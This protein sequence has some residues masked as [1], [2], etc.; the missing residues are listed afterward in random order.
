MFTFKT[1]V[2][3]AGKAEAPK[4]ATEIANGIKRKMWLPDSCAYYRQ[5]L[6]KANGKCVASWPHIS[7]H[8]LTQLGEGVVFK[9]LPFDSRRQQFRNNRRR[10]HKIYGHQVSVQTCR[11]WHPRKAKLSQTCSFSKTSSNHSPCR[12][13]VWQNHFMQTISNHL[14]W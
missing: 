7:P 6:F 3:K 12:I 5:T 11:Q 10:R 13:R 1:S 14:A 9:I 4:S 8:I 2:E